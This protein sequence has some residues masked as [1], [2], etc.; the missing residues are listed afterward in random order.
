MVAYITK[1]LHEAYGPDHSPVPELFTDLHHFL[2]SITHLLPVSVDHIVA[3][4]HAGPFIPAFEDSNLLDVLSLLSSFL[5]LPTHL[6]QVL[7]LL[8]HRG[9]HRVPIIDRASGR[10]VK[11][12]TQSAVSKWLV[13]VS[14][15]RCGLFYVSHLLQTAPR[16][17]RR[18]SERDRGDI[19]ARPVRRHHR[20]V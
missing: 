16:R 12:I 8:G 4:T 20:P 9:V 7:E 14:P 1:M 17:S 5:H 6:R 19:R 11:L 3:M 15:D 13:A 10:I 18:R 2:L